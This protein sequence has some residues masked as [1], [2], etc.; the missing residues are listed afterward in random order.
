MS[1][2]ITPENFIHPDFDAR[3]IKSIRKLLG[4]TAQELATL[5]GVS[6]TTVSRWET[7]KCKPSK[8]A[9]MRLT[10]ISRRKR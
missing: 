6:I 4:L 7:G 10:T 5:L 8:L 9:T 1:V 3:D 2:R